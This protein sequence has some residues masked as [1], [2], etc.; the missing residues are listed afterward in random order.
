MAFLFRRNNGFYYLILHTRRGR[1]IWRSTRTQ[2]REQAE[3][4]AMSKYAELLTRDRGINLSAYFCKILPLV[5]A[6][7]APSTVRLYHNAVKAF[8]ILIGNRNIKFCETLD[9]ENFKALRVEQVSRAKVNIDLRCLKSD[10]RTAVRTGFLVD[11]PCAGVTTL[12]IN[13]TNA[14]S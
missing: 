9:I 1:R 11:S 4:M 8:S 3:A 7:L 13:E 2:D 12:R 5:K 14:C 6:N 10:F